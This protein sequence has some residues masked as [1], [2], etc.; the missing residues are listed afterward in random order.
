[1]DEILRNNRPISSIARDL[2]GQCQTPYDLEDSLR[3]ISANMA[4]VSRRD[5]GD[6]IQVWITGRWVP[7][8]R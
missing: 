3:T 5:C 7:G 2:S 4:T 6:G 8:W 1:M